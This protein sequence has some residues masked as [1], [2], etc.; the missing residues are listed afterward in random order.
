MTGFQSPL[1]IR[2]FLTGLFFVLMGTSLWDCGGIDHELQMKR[3]PYLNPAGTLRGEFEGRRLI[4]DRNGN[5]KETAQLRRSC[6]WS[7]ETRGVCQETI[8]TFYKKALGRNTLHW[9]VVYG[10][11]NEMNISLKDGNGEQRGEVRGSIMLLEGFCLVPGDDE[12]RS[13]V[14]TR[15][16]LLPARDRPVLYETETYSRFGITLG[17]SRT[18]WRISSGR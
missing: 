4:F 16:Y 6:S 5:I 3:G 2:L 13:D 12:K 8:Q 9:R 10:D 14:E 11:R 18:F 1:E 17:S 15:Y 7:D